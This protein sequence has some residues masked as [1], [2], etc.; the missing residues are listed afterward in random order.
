MLTVKQL[1]EELENYGDHLGVVINTTYGQ[2]EIDSV[3]T[4]RIHFDDGRDTDEDPFD[5]LTGVAINTVE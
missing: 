1:R 3:E 5:G 4:M 2:R